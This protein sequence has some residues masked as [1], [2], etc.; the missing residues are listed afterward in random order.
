ML[1]YNVV[2]KKVVIYKNDD[3]IINQRRTS[4]T[5]EFK[6]NEM[7]FIENNG[8]VPL[9]GYFA[10]NGEFINFSTLLDVPCH[11]GDDTIPP[12]YEFLD[13]VSYII[14]G[15]D[16]K[17]FGNINNREYLKYPG[18]QEVVKRGYEYQYGYNTCSLDKFKEELDMELEKLREEI[19]KNSGK[20]DKYS[21]FDQWRYNLL[22]FFQNA[23]FKKPFFEAINRQIKVDNPNDIFKKFDNGSEMCIGSNYS[24]G[25]GYYIKKM[26][27][28]DHFKDIC[29]Q[30]LGYD[31]LERFSPNGKIIKPTRRECLFTNGPT[32]FQKTPR[33]ITSS[34][35]NPNER[36]YNYLLMNWNVH[37]LPR[38]IFNEQTGIYEKEPECLNFHYRDEERIF[39]EEIKSIKRLVPLEDRPK[40]F[41]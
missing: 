28:K 9:M 19:I 41:R 11:D 21:L 6:E 22:L 25:Y 37:I 20:K 3:I 1:I 8:S 23:Y 14:K 13:W 16:Y 26:I 17:T 40:Y 27:L 31:S 10:P 29:V 5:L 15:T 7:S 33:V 39:E 36:F 34:V 24:W 4:M 2:L 30:Y 38:Y 12:A 18:M 35:S 32:K